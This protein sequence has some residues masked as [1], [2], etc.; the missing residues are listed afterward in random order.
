LL[1][2]TL[3][4]GLL[5]SCTTNTMNTQKQAGIHISQ[6]VDPCYSYTVLNDDWRSTDHINYWS[7]YCHDYSNFQGWYRLFLGNSNARIPE[8]HIDSGRCGTYYPL[9]MTGP[10]PTLPGEIVTRT[11]CNNLYGNCYNSYFIQVK[12]CHGNYYVYQLA[13]TYYCYSAYCA[14]IVTL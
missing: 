14:G 9:S 3:S 12:L 4:L 7:G 13:N 8:T 10:H 2:K 6:S 5:A 1:D 11:V